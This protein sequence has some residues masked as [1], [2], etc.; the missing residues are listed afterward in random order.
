M[1]QLYLACV[2]SISDYASPVWW[3]GQ[4]K[5]ADRLQGLQN[6]ALRKILGCFKTSPIRPMEVE[7]CLCPPE[8]RLNHS[9][10]KYAMRTWTLMPNHPIS[11]IMKERI[12]NWNDREQLPKK[13]NQASR[14]LKSLHYML[15]NTEIEPLVSSL[16]AP[17]NISL[18][19]EVEIGNTHKNE[20]VLLHNQVLSQAYGTKQVIYYTDASTSQEAIGI[21]ISLVAYD[22]ADLSTM[23]EYYTI[24]KDSITIYDGELEGIVR[25][26]EH[27]ERQTWDRKL[28]TIFSD[29]QAAI[30]RLKDMSNKAGHIW[31]SRAIKA[32]TNLSDRGI[33]IRL[34]WIPAHMDI[35]GSK[36]ADKLA[37][38]ASYM[39]ADDSYPI[40]LAYINKE[41]E[42]KRCQ[43]W[44][45]ILNNYREDRL[46]ED[47]PSAY[48]GVFP[49]QIRRKPWVP[50]GTRREISSA[51]Y[52]IKLGHG[53]FK[54]YMRRVGH[55]ETDSCSCGS[56]Q[57][58]KHLLLD[59]R[60]NVQNRKKMKERL[61]IKHLS[62]EV[63]LHNSS[64]IAAVLE[65]IN[66]TKISTRRWYLRE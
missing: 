2:I 62:L 8:I 46:L 59:C 37:K 31:V 16:H 17:W 64:G 61:G 47:S 58:A 18:P 11:R 55:I 42:E 49:W 28:I 29:N 7:A 51:F 33:K 10:R 57:T 63:V 12:E 14:I 20:N 22:Q 26:I 19:Y 4:Q 35:R 3:R 36:E 52:Q 32:A 48:T 54:S 60:R 53:Y 1:R 21:G 13:E 6:M 50:R 41:L 5:F 66:D 27:A 40:S 45:I 56:K 24:A 30:L 38:Q 23:T 65:F 39:E 44:H 25:A 15:E 9:R 34:I 43:E